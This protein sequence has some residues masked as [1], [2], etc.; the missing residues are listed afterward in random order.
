MG[1][2]EQRRHDR[3]LCAGLVDVRWSDA[4]GY[5]CETVA[6]LDNL[7]PDGACLLLDSPIPAE[8]RVGIGHLICQV[9]AEIRFCSGPE[10][11]W[12]VGAQFLTGKTAGIRACHPSHVVDPK[13]VTH[14][15][16]D[17]EGRQLST[18]VRTT[19]GCLVLYEAL[20]DRDQEGERDEGDQD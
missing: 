4:D 11:G 5:P 7:S 14:A 13:A 15:D 3:L 20:R 8:T 16:Q 12:V 1:I 19:V 2:P 18:A 9:E 17:T 10:L 6:N